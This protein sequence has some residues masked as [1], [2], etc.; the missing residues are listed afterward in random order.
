[1]EKKQLLA[2]EKKFSLI[3]ERLAL[4]LIENHSNFSETVIIGL[5]PRGIY[6]SERIISTLK[7]ILKIETIASGNLDITFFRDDFRTHD[8]P[9]IPSKTEMEIEIE[10][11]K[12]IL[13]DDVLFTGRTIRS[14]IDALL[15]YGRPQKVEL[16]VLVDRLYSR[17]LPI[18]ANYAGLK[19]DTINSEKVIVNWKHIDSED[20]IWL[21]Q[22]N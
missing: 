2:N 17:D 6:V 9:L 7:R 11:K 13:V 5:Q 20:S 16:L 1:V 10:N 4:E 8:T 15:S 18:Q 21:M 14:G 3:I 12:V 22:K 19:I